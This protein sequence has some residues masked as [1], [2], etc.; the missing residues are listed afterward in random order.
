MMDILA[1]S[2]RPQSWPQPNK[3][4]HLQRRAVA[5]RSVT[6]RHGP[7]TNRYGGRSADDGATQGG[8]GW[9]AGGEGGRGQTVGTATFPDD[10]GAARR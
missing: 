5:A 7:M 6:R 8:G 1:A 4:V 9:E 2:P 10:S 3:R